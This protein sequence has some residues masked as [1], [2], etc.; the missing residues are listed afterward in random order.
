MEEVVMKG[1]VGKY[2]LIASVIS[3]IVLSVVFVLLAILKKS[4]MATP[5]YTQVDIT[6]GAVFV[7]ILSMIVSASVWPNIVE[8]RLKNKS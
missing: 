1:K 3:S 2:S 4:G 6:A 7:F 5:L 8:K